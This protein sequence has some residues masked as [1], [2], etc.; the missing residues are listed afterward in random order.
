MKGY[1][2]KL[3]AVLKIRKL[4]EEQCKMEIGRIQVKINSYKE[5]IEQH[6]DG[7]KQAY[8][9][10]EQALAG[11]MNGQ[12]LRFHTFFVSGKR[13]HIEK[14]N[15][16]IQMLTSQVNEKFNELKYLRADSKVIDN[17]KEKDRTKYK[18][19]LQKKQFEEME[20]QVQN[21]KQSIQ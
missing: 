5:Q 15:S 9:S 7:I 2:F 17:M 20:E 1:K 21:W 8:E 4:K 11:G 6:Q 10:N 19:A 13:A 12:E 16:E 18:K 3:E 14:I